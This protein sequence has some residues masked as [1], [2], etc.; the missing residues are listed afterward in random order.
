M[1]ILETA[2]SSYAFSTHLAKFA[3]PGINR[4]FGDVVLFRDI[5]DGRH[6]RFAQDFHYLTLSKLAS[7]HSYPKGVFAA[8]GTIGK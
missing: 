2:Q 5:I 6:A 1:R 4:A 3:V 8:I 7:L